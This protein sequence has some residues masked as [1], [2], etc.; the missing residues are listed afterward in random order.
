[1]ALGWCVCVN[2]GAGGRVRDGT[3]GDRGEGG[4]A[5]RHVVVHANANARFFC[6]GGWLGGD[7]RGAGFGARAGRTTY[8]PVLVIGPVFFSGP[9]PGNLRGR[10]VPGRHPARPNVSST[11]RN[12]PSTDVFT[13]PPRGPRESRWRACLARS[14][15]PRRACGR[16]RGERGVL[17][18]ARSVADARRGVRRRGRQTRPAPRNRPPRSTRHLFDHWATSRF[19]RRGSADLGQILGKSPSLLPRSE[20]AQKCL[21]C[22]FCPRWDGM[23]RTRRG[24]ARGVSTLKPRR[25]SPVGVSRT[26]RRAN[27]VRGRARATR[28]GRWGLAGR[29]VTHSIWRPVIGREERGPIT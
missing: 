3:E 5:R 21:V 18:R 15:A 23:T 10:L 22:T 13:Y 29:D 28:R 9:R 25:R 2:A 24:G 19:A 4:R 7:P 26:R 1:M 16:D 20:K 12:S 27:V 11:T 8:L 17:E 14:S 6:P